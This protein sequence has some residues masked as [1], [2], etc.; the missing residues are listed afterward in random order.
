MFHIITITNITRILF[1]YS[2]N[3]M[4]FTITATITKCISN[5]KFY[6]INNTL[7]NNVICRYTTKIRNEMHK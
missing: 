4:Q 3:N 5:A 2:V 1:S 6:I 7:C